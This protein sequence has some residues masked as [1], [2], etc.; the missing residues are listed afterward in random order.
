MGLGTRLLRAPRP[1]VSTSNMLGTCDK[2][3]LTIRQKFLF[4]LPLSTGASLVTFSL[5][6]NKMTGLYGILALLTGYHLSWCTTSV[7]LKL[8]Q[9]R[10]SNLAVAML[11]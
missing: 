9:E 10:F 11:D 5:L 1:Q 4:T 6:L 7:Y 2:Q 3:S 8:I